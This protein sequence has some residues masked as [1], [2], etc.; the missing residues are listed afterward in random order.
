M[1]NLGAI[2]IVVFLGIGMLTVAGMAIVTIINDIQDMKRKKEE[3]K[4]EEDARAWG[5]RR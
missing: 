2:A 3:W 1:S 4:R 5:N